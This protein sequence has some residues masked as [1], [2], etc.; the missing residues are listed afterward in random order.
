MY[1]TILQHVTVSLGGRLLLN[2]INLTMNAGE[3]WAIVG[4][5]GSGKTTLAKALAGQIFYRGE[6][7]IVDS[8]GSPVEPRIVLIDQQHQ[9]K[10]KSNVSNFYYQQRF[11]SAD[12][13]DTHD[14]AT[15]LDYHAE[16]NLDHWI[17]LFGLTDLLERP[18]IQLSNGENKRL[19][20]VK[21]MKKNPDLLIMDNPF[22]GLD[23]K[24]RNTLEDALSE[25]CTLGKQIILISS[26]DKLPD[27]ISHVAILEKGEIQSTQTHH[28]YKKRT[29]K[30]ESCTIDLPNYTTKEPSENDHAM[31]IEMRNV[32][33][34]YNNT[35]ILSNINWTVRKGERWC[36]AGHNGSGKST[37]LSLINADNPQAYANEIYLFGRKRGSG[38]SIWDIKKNIGFVSPELHMF[39]EKGITVFEAVASGLYDTIGLF[40]YVPA[41]DREV[42]EDWLKAMG[43]E[44]LKEK[45]MH[46][47]SLGEQRTVMLARALVKTPALLILDEPCQGL[48]KQ[49][50]ERFKSILDA[51]AAK[52]N[53]TMIY[54][55]HYAE[56]V[57]SCFNHF[58]QLEKGKI[59]E[60][61]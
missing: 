22:I 54:V 49:Q 10:N 46:Q 55:S 23:S 44:M 30:T 27:A 45:I 32:N 43:I 58:L 25:L 26:I 20:L 8:D 35:C 11:N 59:I 17:K 1:Q 56:D 14:L 24:S 60:S 61:I 6:I 13:E 38:E 41:A 52:T 47:L 48:D 5:S 57:P 16:S 33:I 9:F 7:S 18:L 39:F 42:V 51:L 15:E 29:I 53:V 3:Q 28:A 31:I 21:A 2:N 40:R 36:V 4:N 37:L 34:A 19:Q 50:T 12:A